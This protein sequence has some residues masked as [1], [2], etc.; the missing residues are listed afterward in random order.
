MT[1]TRCYFF[2]VLSAHFMVLVTLFF[3]KVTG[4][5]KPVLIKQFTVVLVHPLVGLT[6]VFVNEAEKKTVIRFVHSE[7]LGAV[8]YQ[9][10]VCQSCINGS[11]VFLLTSCLT[12]CFLLSSNCTEWMEK[13]LKKL[14]CDTF[15][16]FEEKER[17]KN[18]ACY[19]FTSKAFV[20]NAPSIFCLFLL[21]YLFF[22][23]SC[24]LSFILFLL[25]F[26]FGFSI[27]VLLLFNS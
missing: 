2:L 7:V 11:P 8:S 25:G 5:I 22:V 26:F 27:S 3:Y 19:T 4:G 18:V 24:F 14:H 1:L 17:S 12:V 21:I 23:F 9:C 13:G 15:L 10:T 16:D 6:S 20:T